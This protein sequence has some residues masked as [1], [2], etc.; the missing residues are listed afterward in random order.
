MTYSLSFLERLYP[1][2][3]LPAT[4]FSQA[5]PGIKPHLLTLTTNFQMPFYR[6]ILLALGVCSVSKK[7][8]SNILKAGPGMAITI[9]VGGAAESLSARPGTADLTLRKRCVRSFVTIFWTGMEWR[10]IWFHLEA[11]IHQTRYPTRVRRQAFHRD[12]SIHMLTT[13][14]TARIS[15]RC[16]PL[17][18][19]T[20]VAF[21]LLCSNEICVSFHFLTHVNVGALDRYTSRCPTKRERRCTRYNGSS[22]R[23]LD[24]RSPCS[25]GGGC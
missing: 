18:K 9:V 5:F 22:N 6:D 19:M 3:H 15:Y 10:L 2:Q 7:S 8:C 4:G 12:L 17:G 23:Y 24:S 21:L 14:L 25:M 20:C 16:F 11:G 13:A 1:H